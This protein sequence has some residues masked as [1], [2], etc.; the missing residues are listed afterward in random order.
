MSLASFVIRQRSR[1]HVAPLLGGSALLGAPFAAISTTTPA[2]GAPTPAGSAHDVADRV[3]IGF[4]PGV[5]AAEA[6]DAVAGVAA[7]CPHPKKRGGSPD[8]VKETPGQSGNLS[9]MDGTK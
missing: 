5:R 2:R 9:A 6:I 1:R 4:E 8:R 7:T 3:L